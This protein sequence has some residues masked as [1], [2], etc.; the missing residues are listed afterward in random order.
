MKPTQRKMAA[1]D[2]SRN[3]KKRKDL[4]RFDDIASAIESYMK[5]NRITTNQY[6]AQA[7]HI[8]KIEVRFR[9]VK[10]N[11][12]ESKQCP[13][14]G[15]K[16]LVVLIEHRSSRKIASHRLT[17]C[18][19]V[20]SFIVSRSVETFNRF[21]RSPIV[22]TT[23]D[24]PS[25]TVAWQFTEGAVRTESKLLYFKQSINWFCTTIGKFDSKFSINRFQITFGH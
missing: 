17:S 22:K 1:I 4:K 20:F 7:I 25:Q 2:Q 19:C 6:A 8:K 24:C 10:F 9:F 18:V 3:P 13:W 21:D 11:E 12:W 23:R 5:Q 16:P 14:N 15:V